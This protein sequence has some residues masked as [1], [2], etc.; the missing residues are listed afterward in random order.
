MTVKLRSNL[1]EQLK[2]ADASDLLEIILELHPQAESPP[3]AAPKTRSRSEKIAAKKEAFSRNVA[4]VEEAIRKVGGEI[5]GLAWINQTVRA[6]VPAQGVK[7]LSEHE[8]VA[9]LDIPHPVKLDVG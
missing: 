9:A 8:K 2:K 6:R 5:T 7:E 3:T 1:A 4:P